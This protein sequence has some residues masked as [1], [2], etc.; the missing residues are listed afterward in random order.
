MFAFDM[1]RVFAVLMLIA[2]VP[3]F[4]QDKAAKDREAL[5]RMQRS[6][7]KAQQDISALNRE[8]SE[9]STKLEAAQKS[10]DTA[11]ADVTR[12]R[13][14]TTVA[15]KDL[16][17]LKVG[18]EALQRKLEDTEKQLLVAGE[19]FKELDLLQKKTEGERIS[20]G[21][22]LKQES[23][24][25]QICNAA[26]EKLYGLVR[27]VSRQYE[28]TAREQ[29]DPVFGL[30]MVEIENQLELYRDRADEGRLRRP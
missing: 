4:A 26:N 14:R 13:Q 15:E 24:A 21:A 28:K 18:H 17:E 9:L 27:E 2:V 7:A 6:L 20:T 11:K 19:R 12:I 1:S 16:R 30:R 29:A 10:A 23:A 22:R 8:K 5:V 3:A 25:L